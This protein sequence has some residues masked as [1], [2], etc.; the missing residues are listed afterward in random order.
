MNY[1]ADYHTHST[2]CDGADS[3]EQMIKS[4]IKDKV[5]I[6]GFSNHSMY[7]FAET[8]HIAPKE[9]FNY[10][11]GIN[12]LKSKYKE[13]IKILCGFEADFIPSLCESSF[14]RFS[15]FN[16]DYLIGSVHY[17]VNEKGFVTVDESAEGVLQ[18][19]NKL[20]NGNAKKFVQEYF[21]LQRQM[22][23]NC[24]FTILGHPDLIRVRNASLKLFDE[25]ELWYKNE[26][27]DLIKS[28]KKSDVLVEINTGAIFRKKMDDVYPSAYFLELMH[29]KNIPIIFCSD[30]HSKNAI[31]ANF[32][33]AKIAACKAGYTERAILLPSTNTKATIQMQQ[34]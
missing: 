25:N 20:F 9:H 24:D 7:P 17:I 1:K 29:D 27:K 30:A 13:E 14:N 19:V 10:S 18:G 8:W 3:L 6:L 32:D 4:A 33:R 22:L 31:C 12:L 34:L 28:I 21:Y 23:K 2:Y 26:I 11:N 15:Q 16:P 5:D